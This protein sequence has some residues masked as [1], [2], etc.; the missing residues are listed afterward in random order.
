MATIESSLS[1]NARCAVCARCICTLYLHSARMCAWATAGTSLCLTE[2]WWA[3]FAWRSRRWTKPLCS[4][5]RL[6][7]EM[8]EKP[9]SSE[10]VRVWHG[11]SANVVSRSVTQ[12]PPFHPPPTSLLGPFQTYTNTHPYTRINQPW[13]MWNVC[14]TEIINN[15]VGLSARCFSRSHTLRDDGSSA[16]SIQSDAV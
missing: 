5:V 4:V 8:N 7:S 15:K 10:C 6:S 12:P 2:S 13:A 1:I 11:R 16:R 3:V 14:H 9:T